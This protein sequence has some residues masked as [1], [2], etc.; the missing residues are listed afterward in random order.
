MPIIMQSLKL[1][2]RN[3][4]N[5]FLLLL[6]VFIGCKCGNISEEV[7]VLQTTPIQPKTYY[8]LEAIDLGINSKRD[9]SFEFNDKQLAKEGDLY[10]SEE[11]MVYQTKEEKWYAT[12][13]G[14]G[15]IS[16]NLKVSHHG[17]LVQEV[18]ISTTPEVFGYRDELGKEWPGMCNIGS[19]CFANSAYKLIARC[20]GFD[21]ALSK[22]IEGGINTSLRNIVNGIRL[23]KRSALPEDTVNS[24]VSALFLD[25]LSENAGERFNNRMQNDAFSFFNEITFSLYPVNDLLLQEWKNKNMIDKFKQ[26]RHP[27]YYISKVTTTDGSNYVGISQ[28]IYPLI[29]DIQAHVQSMDEKYLSLPQFFIYLSNVAAHKEETKIIENL[30]VP[31]WDYET[32]KKPEEKTYKLIGFFQHIPGHYLAYI[33]FNAQGWYQ[34]SDSS[35][36]PV[37]PLKSVA[38]E[39]LVAIYELQE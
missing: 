17:N 36:K 25:K 4:L 20:S 19:T 31:L 6:L 16:S 27:F 5:C 8:N 37:A 2:E 28:H 22:D 9:L 3:S 21:E 15:S 34:H 10:L 38:S 33:N 35:V 39:N 24:K 12:V 23:G 13:I 7:D 14:R 32:D 26:E 30:Q 29:P 18:S 1:M 11:L